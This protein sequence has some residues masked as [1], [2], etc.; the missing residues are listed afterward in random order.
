[1]CQVATPLQTPLICFSSLVFALLRG[2]L[3]A[4]FWWGCLR[5][6]GTWYGSQSNR[7]D[8]SWNI[9]HILCLRHWFWSLFRGNGFL[10][11]GL[12]PISILREHS[13]SHGCWLTRLD[14]WNRIGHGRHYF[15]VCLIS[16]SEL[17]SSMGA[18][19]HSS[20]KPTVLFGTATLGLGYRHRRVNLWCL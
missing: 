8:R 18:Y 19:Q 13:S 2:S 5:L 9:A 3:A 14:Q 6:P 11:R 16:A 7:G 1:M 12:S 10:C 4:G 17:L 20:T 15:K